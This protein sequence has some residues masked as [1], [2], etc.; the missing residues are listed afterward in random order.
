M[1]IYNALL[2]AGHNKPVISKV[3]Y[4]ERRDYRNLPQEYVVNYQGRRE[5]IF[6]Y[7]AIKLWDFTEEIIAGELKELAPLLILL[8]KEKNEEVLIRSKELILESEDKKWQAE[9]LS[10]AVTVAGRY[11]PKDFL[12]KFFKEVL[13][14][15]RIAKY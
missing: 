10:L 2:T 14:S 3:V 12:L 5:N 11:F 6:I 15:Y 9:A 4:L 8:T 7:Q 13:S 1:H